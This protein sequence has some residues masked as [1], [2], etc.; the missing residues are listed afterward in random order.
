MKNFLKRNTGLA[1]NVDRIESR[2]GNVMVRG[3]A[4]D[5]KSDA[6][7]VLKVQDAGRWKHIIKESG[8]RH[9]WKIQR[10][11]EG[12]GRALHFWSSRLYRS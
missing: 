1:A 9:R 6:A 10:C 8:F 2:Y 7:T 4:L 3:W 12:I 11:S 5:R